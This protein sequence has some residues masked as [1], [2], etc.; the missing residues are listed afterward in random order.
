MDLLAS[1][2]ANNDRIKQQEDSSERS[3]AEQVDAPSIEA[4]GPEEIHALKAKKEDENVGEGARDESLTDHPA[5]QSLEEDDEMAADILRSLASAWPPQKV[6][7][8][9]SFALKR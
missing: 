4:N 5:H 6:S 1:V 3:E 9:V 2:N 7:S 8:R